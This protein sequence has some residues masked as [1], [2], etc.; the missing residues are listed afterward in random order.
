MAYFN[1]LALLFTLLALSDAAPL[2]HDTHGEAD[3][4]CPLMVK[5]LDAVR[6]IPAAKVGVKVFRAD[7]VGTWKLIATG[8]TSDE[9]EIHDLTNEEEF[10]EGDYKVEFATKP[11]WRKSGL[12]PLHEYADT[13]DYIMS[14]SYGSYPTLIR[15]ARLL[16]NVVFPPRP[17]SQ[18]VGHKRHYSKYH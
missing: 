5:I 18:G 2:G 8:I 6:G 15:S 7:E 14:F 9:G 4:K 11:Y 13:Q 3:T 10:I 16:L 12:S 17:Y 1:F